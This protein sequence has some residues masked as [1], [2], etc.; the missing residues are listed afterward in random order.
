MLTRFAAVFIDT[1]NIPKPTTDAG[2]LDFILSIIFGM[3][4][5]IA[6]LVIVIAGFKYI[7]SKGEAREMT[8]AKNMIIYALVGLVV[9]ILA[10]S[11]VLFVI[12]NV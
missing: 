4:G 7:L 5:L 12:N 11:I 3:L 10:Y 2:K 9:C 6:V 8:N 1:T